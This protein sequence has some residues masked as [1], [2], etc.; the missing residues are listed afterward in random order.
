MSFQHEL[1]PTYDSWILDFVVPNDEAIFHKTS[2][3]VVDNNYS[4]T[5]VNEKVFFPQHDYYNN[6]S[7]TID[8]SAFHFL[9]NL[10]EHFISSPNFILGNIEPGNYKIFP[11]SCETI[12]DEGM[13]AKNS[14][15]NY[16]FASSFKDIIHKD[17][18]F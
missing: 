2:S 7:A 9:Q 13:A 10:K 16:I 14:D 1:V 5:K 8:S 4:T 6:D 15:T 17:S 12:M 11:F 3:S 18:F